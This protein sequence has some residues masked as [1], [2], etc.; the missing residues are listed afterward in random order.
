M[1]ITPLK[2]SCKNRLVMAPSIV[3]VKA[4]THMTHKICANISNSPLVNPAIHTNHNF[5]GQMCGIHFWQSKLDFL[6]P[7]KPI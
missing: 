3:T 1:L 4:L 7:N 6:D 2:Q 5:T